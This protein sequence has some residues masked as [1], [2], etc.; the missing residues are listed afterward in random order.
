MSKTVIFIFLLV[1]AIFLFDVYIIAKMGA[2]ESISSYIIRWSKD[3]P[4]ISFLTGFV[5]GHLFWRMPDSRVYSK[6]EK[7]K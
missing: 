5:A 7:T 2:S 1:A 4:S 6:K 3:Y